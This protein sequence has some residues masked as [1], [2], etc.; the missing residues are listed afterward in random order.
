MK[1][2]FSLTIVSLLAVIVLVGVGFAGWIIANPSA[3]DKADGSFTTYGVEDKSYTVKIEEKTV[4]QKI[5]F[6]QPSSETGVT[7]PWLTAS[8]DVLAEV[9]TATF[10]ITLEGDIAS[11]PENLY[12]SMTSFTGE[13]TAPVAD[14]KFAELVADNY[15]VY[16]TVS[17]TENSSES[18]TAQ[19]LPKWTDSVTIPTNAFADGEDGAKTLD[20][21]VTFGWGTAFN[22]KN[23][24]LYFNQDKTIADKEAAKTALTALNGLNGVKYSV[25]VSNTEPNAE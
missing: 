15:I 18:A 17:Y 25:T 23:P 12:L 11:V 22:S 19:A 4:G 3:E 21:T 20:V 5:V 1:R 9:L 13:S 7:N 8:E 16:P 6:G 10:T 14:T 2:K 24:Y